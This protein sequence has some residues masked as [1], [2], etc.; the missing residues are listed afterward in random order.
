MDQ[1]SQPVSA[2]LEASHDRIDV[3]PIGG[4]GQSPRGVGQQLLHQ[5]AGE[6]VRPREHDLLELHDVF[7]RPPVRH[8]ARRVHPE[9]SVLR[10]PGPDG[11]EVLQRE[12]ERV[13]PP[14]ALAACR[15]LAV[16]AEP[17]A[18]RP[19]APKVRF[20]RVDVRRGRG[21]RRSEDV[22]EH[23]D[24]PDN[25]VGVDP[26]GRRGEDGRLSEEAAPPGILQRH[27]TDSNCTVIS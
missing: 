5:A 2:G 19:G 21:R 27:L 6:L 22:L 13:D 8:F 23:P 11:I 17:L 3:R 26:V 4:A 14:V 10:P 9:F 20:Q 7:E 15:D 16:E 18:E 25:R 24:A 1:V 12:A